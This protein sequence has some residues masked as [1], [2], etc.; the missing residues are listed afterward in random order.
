MNTFLTILNFIMFYGL[1]PVSFL[2]LRKAYKI[3]L[4]KD[5]SMVALKRGESPPD[6]KKFAPYQTV[7]NLIAG[8]VLAGL[9]VYIFVIAIMNVVELSRTELVIRGVN[10]VVDS[11]SGYLNIYDPEPPFPHHYRT[12]TS[13][14]GVTI[15]LKF[16]FEFII[17]RQAHLKIKK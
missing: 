4:K 14:A 12:W 17:S 9:F 13:I 2:F 5:Y 3:G 8:L 15:F 11:L 1:I 10:N 7:V 6:P 16:I